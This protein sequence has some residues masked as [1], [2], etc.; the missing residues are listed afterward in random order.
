MGYSLEHNE[1]HNKLS[2]SVSPQ[3]FSFNVVQ[4]GIKSSEEKLN[5]WGVSYFTRSNA[6]PSGAALL[7]TD[8][9]QNITVFTELLKNERHQFRFNG[10][11]RNLQVVRS[12]VPNLKADNSLLG[13]AEYQVNEWRGLVTGNVLYELGAGQEQK[14][15][16]AFLE[17]P[18]GQGEYTWIDYNNNGIKELNEFEI[19][20]FPDQS[21]FVRIFR[22]TNQ[23]IRSNFTGINQNLTLNAAS[24]FKDSKKSFQIFLKK[25]SN[26]TALRVDKRVLGVGALAFNPYQTNVAND[27]LLSYN[28]YFRNSLFFDRQNPVF[29]LDINYQQ[30]G[31][32]ILLTN[33]F[34]S[35]NRTESSVRLRWNFIRKANFMVE[36]KQ[37]DKQYLSE[38]FSA[39]NY[40]IKF[41]ETVPEFSYQFTNNFKTILSGGLSTQ[42]NAGEYGGESTLNF[43]ISSEIKY[44]LLKKGIFSA[45]AN[46]INNQF[47]GKNNSSVGYE[48]LDGLQPGNN[49][50]WNVGFQRTISNGIQLNF[51]YEGRKSADV[52]AIHTGGMQVRA[53][54]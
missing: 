36:F 53:F 6:Y 42:Q 44:N 7:Q 24:L 45:R 13:R 43:R 20:R 40:K 2:D 23:F 10:T 39:N 51:T 32:K 1:V 33:G 35:R 48:M 52:R 3:S 5:R 41:Y 31:S 22:T 17:V 9:S 4:A 16:F 18:A 25:L 19:S 28:S 11:Y 30:N 29:G 15:D 47:E 12:I 27:K 34:D 37:G 8:R 21:K 14:R 26:I 49:L 50:T 54:F 46:S 38:L